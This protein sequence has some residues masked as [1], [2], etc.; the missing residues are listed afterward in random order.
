MA[1]P[2]WSAVLST[3]SGTS[4]TSSTAWTTALT[5]GNLVVVVIGMS[6]TTNDSSPSVSSVS[7]GTDSLTLLT[8]AK[9]NNGTGKT[10]IFVEVWAGRVATASQRTLT[11]SIGGT[12]CS[13]VTYGGEYS[14]TTYSRV[15]NV[16]AKTGT[17]SSTSPS[18][19]ASA[20]TSGAIFTLAGF[21]SLSTTDLTVPTSTPS[22][23]TM[24][25]PA[26]GTKH[27]SGGGTGSNASGNV[28]ITL[29]DLALPNNVN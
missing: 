10:G 20:A 22:G 15:L 27:V 23:S 6:G 4:V 2:Q 13:I 26:S 11:V 3:G 5:V 28:A 25:A 9:V 21:A 16:V 7:L 14:G 24:E 29:D 17:G 8:G 12:V 19:R 1:V 18:T